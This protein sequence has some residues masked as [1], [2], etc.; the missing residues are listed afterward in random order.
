M[1]AE[2]RP[3]AEQVLLG[4]I[5]AVRGAIDKQNEELKAAGKPAVKADSLLKVAEDLR[6]GALAAV[7]RDRA[8]AAVALVD[9]LDLRDLRSVVNAAGDAGR[10]E[11]ARAL[12]AQL[13]EAL[14]N[15]VEKEHAAWL[16]DLTETVAAGRVVRALRLSSRPP[17]P[18]PRSPATWRRSWP[19]PRPRR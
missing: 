9:E 4:G 19:R 6:P 3:I 14:T 16:A 1:P 17:R 15:R 10:D 11:E 2:Q 5:P 8:E 7:W 13:R 12:A 18:A